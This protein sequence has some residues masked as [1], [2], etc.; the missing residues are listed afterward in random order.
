[1]GHSIH[2]TKHNILKDTFWE[3]PT[4]KFSEWL[5]DNNIDLKDSLNIVKINIEGAEWEFFNDIVDSKLNKHIHIYC[6]AGHDVEKISNFVKEGIVE[7]YYELLKKNDIFLHRWVL[8]WKVERNADIHKMI[9]DK[10]RLLNDKSSLE[11]NENSSNIIQSL[12]IGEKLTLNLAI[13]E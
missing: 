10:Y 13:F 7:K 2:S 5:K 11:Y 1:M 3:V 9:K 8:T 6:G 4:I 12:W